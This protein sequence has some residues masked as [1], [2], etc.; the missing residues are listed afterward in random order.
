M[1]RL[2]LLLAL[3]LAACG[4]EEGADPPAVEGACAEVSGRITDE[5]PDAASAIEARLMCEEAGSA[6]GDEAYLTRETIVCLAR[7]G[8]LE[9]GLTDWEVSIRYDAR[10]ERVVW[11][12][13][14]QT[15]DDPSDFRQEGEV[16]V[17]DAITGVL[18][19]ELGWTAIA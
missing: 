12:V 7:E 15:V 18:V 6:C 4:T 1:K 19:E 2:T 13:K 3:A 17:F 10:N 11:N 5:D 8:G 14:N 16:W 9:E